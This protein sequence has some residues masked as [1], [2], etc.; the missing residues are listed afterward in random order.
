MVIYNFNLT[1]SHAVV[2]IMMKW[3][4]KWQQLQNLA[5]MNITIKQHISKISKKRKEKENM[6]VLA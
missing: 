4:L 3:L 1:T 2:W 5:L 6:N